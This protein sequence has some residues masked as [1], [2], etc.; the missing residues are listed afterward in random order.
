M[1]TKQPSDGNY[2]PWVG[3]DWRPSGWP[4]V[5][6]SVSQDDRKK[7][8][9]R[10]AEIAQRIN[11]DRPAKAAKQMIELAD[12]EYKQIRYFRFERQDTDRKKPG[13]PRS[14][15]SSADEPLAAHFIGYVNLARACYAIEKGLSMP[16]K[17]DSN[18]RKY[19]HE[20]F[21]GTSLV[22]EAKVD[23]D[24]ALS[25]DEIVTRYL[26]KIETVIRRTEIDSFWQKMRQQPFDRV[27]VDDADLDGLNDLERLATKFGELAGR[28]SLIRNGIAVDD[29]SWTFTKIQTPDGEIPDWALPSFRL[30]EIAFPIA[31]KALPIPF[32]LADGFRP[33]AFEPYVP[34]DDDGHWDYHRFS[35]AALQWLNEWG[36]NGEAFYLQGNL[37]HDS[38]LPWEDL[39]MHG[40]C[41]LVLGLCPSADGS[42]QYKLSWYLLENDS[43][44]N[45]ICLPDL[46]SSLFALHERQYSAWESISMEYEERLGLIVEKEGQKPTHLVKDWHCLRQEWVGRYVLMERNNID[47]YEMDLICRMPFCADLPTKSDTSLPVPPDTVIEALLHNE[48][49]IDAGDRLSRRIEASC[50]EI[51]KAGMAHYHHMNEELDK[52]L[53]GIVSEA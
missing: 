7:L 46:T 52:I 3:R 17:N 34:D 53:A 11:P 14:K 15:D 9:R 8:A 33:E 6:D 13:R 40:I 37:D 49:V 32:E 1:T 2:L 10:L 12:R 23:I 42:I 29:R 45:R 31:V 35:A 27:E 22:P 44:D 39:E 4:N 21:K 50:A 16:E 18:W 51:V 25:L 19:E 24:S 47:E 41:N 28:E 30:G 38:S 20:F 26:Q 48:A 43:G 5:P 36:A